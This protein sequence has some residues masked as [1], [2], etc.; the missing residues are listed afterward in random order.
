MDAWSGSLLTKLVAWEKV[1]KRERHKTDKAIKRLIA[2]TL[3]RLAAE[4]LRDCEADHAPAT[5]AD[6]NRRSVLHK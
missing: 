1:W 6:E 5:E 2:K 3:Q 4:A